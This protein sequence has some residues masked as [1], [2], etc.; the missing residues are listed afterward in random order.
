MR[1]CWRF[2]LV[3]VGRLRFFYLYQ[4]VRYDPLG[5]TRLSFWVVAFDALPYW[6]DLPFY[7]VFVLAVEEIFLRWRGSVFW[8]TLLSLGKIERVVF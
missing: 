2:E 7:D 8:R 6:Y 4:S 5:W 3:A 1:G